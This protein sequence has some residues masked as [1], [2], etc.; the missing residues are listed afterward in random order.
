MNGLDSSNVVWHT[1][2]FDE[3]VDLKL[4][5]LTSYDI[6]SESYEEGGIKY[7]ASDGSHPNLYFIP[8]MR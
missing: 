6:F 8:L 4:E 7:G 2:V 1:V 3:P 5:A